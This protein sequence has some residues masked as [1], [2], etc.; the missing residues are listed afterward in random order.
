MDTVRLDGRTKTV[1]MNL[2]LNLIGLIPT[3][4]IN[5]AIGTVFDSHYEEKRRNP[6]SDVEQ[7]LLPPPLQGEQAL[8]QPASFTWNADMEFA[9]N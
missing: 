4:E 9:S 1:E 2:Y 6:E 8:L 7:T 5:Q 3:A